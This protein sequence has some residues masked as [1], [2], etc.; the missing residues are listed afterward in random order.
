MHTSADC[1][2]I[3][4]VH[5]T[6]QWALLSSRPAV[7]SR[8]QLGTQLLWGIQCFGLNLEIAGNFLPVAP[9]QPQAQLTLWRA[10]CMAKWGIM[11]STCT[12]IKKTLTGRPAA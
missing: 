7:N 8:C 3:C 10:V 11:C 4:R 2:H 9:Q 12:Y 5:A 6:A 1:C